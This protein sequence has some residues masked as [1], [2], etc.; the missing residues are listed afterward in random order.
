[1][2][3]SYLQVSHRSIDFGVVFYIEF[4]MVLGASQGVFDHH[5]AKYTFNRLGVLSLFP[6]IARWLWKL[7]T[8]PQFWVCLIV[9]FHFQCVFKLAEFPALN[10]H[11]DEPR[12]LQAVVTGVHF[13]C[14]YKPLIHGIS[15]L[16]DLVT[17]VTNHSLSG[18]CQLQVPP[19][20]KTISGI[21]AMSDFSQFGV[22]HSE[23]QPTQMVN[24]DIL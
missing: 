2:I 15:Q 8:F 22:K 11:L 12:S 1:M 14:S 10:S 13:I 9:I 20:Q 21:S 16:G 6:D 5:V 17:R 24:W 3:L 7:Y 19:L 4:P 18:I 23:S